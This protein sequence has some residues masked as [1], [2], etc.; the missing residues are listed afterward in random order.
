MVFRIAD[1]KFLVNDLSHG[2]E[3][4]SNELFDPIESSPK[5]PRLIK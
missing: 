3:E 4:D 1:Y 5:Q 2:M